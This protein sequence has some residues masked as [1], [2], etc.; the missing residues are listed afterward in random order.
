MTAK[1]VVHRSFLGVI[2]RRPASIQMHG[3]ISYHINNN[4]FHR[5]PIG[6]KSK[7]GHDMVQLHQEGKDLDVTGFL[8]RCA[9]GNRLGILINRYT[10][11][12]FTSATPESCTYAVVE[13]GHA[14]Q[15]QLTAFQILSIN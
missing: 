13:L 6:A 15:K 14:N 4:Y 3:C 11:T 2:V 8:F 7:A 5:P 12:V 9:P 1:V 10:N